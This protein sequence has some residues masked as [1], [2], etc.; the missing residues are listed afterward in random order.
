MSHIHF[1]IS[2]IEATHHVQ[3]SSERIQSRKTSFKDKPNYLKTKSYGIRAS[4][5]LAVTWIKRPNSQEPSKSHPFSLDS[6]NHW[7]IKHLSV[8]LV[9]HDQ[10]VALSRR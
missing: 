3:F 2:F 1:S 10:V 7:S 4:E 8:P 9:Y 5:P 6:G